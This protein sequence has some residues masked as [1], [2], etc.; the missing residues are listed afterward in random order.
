M[1]QIFIPTLVAITSVGAYLVGAKGLRLPGRG[2]RLAASKM[3]ECFGMTF[4]FLGV[5]VAAG[6]VGILAA[7]ALTGG[8]V[9]LYLAADG[10]MLGLSLIQGV[11][12]QWWRDLSARSSRDSSPSR[13]PGTQG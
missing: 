1:E 4:V 8:F 10:T 9:S 12:F 3:L 2:I 11:T 7:R 13:N 5:N 6:M